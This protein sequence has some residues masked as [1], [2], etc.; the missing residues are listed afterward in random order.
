M[1]FAQVDGVGRT[2][3]FPRFGCVERGDLMAVRKKL[4][5]DELPKPSRPSGDDDAH[6]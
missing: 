5:H 2:R 3:T 6:V 1:S 4:P